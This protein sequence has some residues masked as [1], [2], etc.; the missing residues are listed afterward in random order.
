MTSKYKVRYEILL[1]ETMPEQTNAEGKRTH[2]ATYASDKRN[3]GYNI[4]VVGPHANEFAGEEV[5]VETKNGEEHTERLLRLLW[6]GPDLDPATKEPTGRLAALYSFE[7]R[8]K[9]VVKPV[10]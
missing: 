5:P 8:P 9:E 2:K 7:S 3:S 6:S 1:G 4:R 10:F